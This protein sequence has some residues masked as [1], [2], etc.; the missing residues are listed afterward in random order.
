MTLIFVK[1]S[2]CRMF[3]PN[4][5]SHIKEGILFASGQIGTMILSSVN[6]TVVD[7]GE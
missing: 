6:F 7:R 4:T 5:V 2:F 1:S 3:F